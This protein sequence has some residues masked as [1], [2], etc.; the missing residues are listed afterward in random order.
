M[1]SDAASVLVVDDDGFIRR[2]VE[3]EC[4]AR[5][6]LVVAAADGLEATR[7]L[8]VRDFDVV[9]VDLELPNLD[10]LS[11]IRLLKDASP[12]TEVIVLT[13]HNQLN[14]ALEC[15]RLG[16]FDFVAKSEELRDLFPAVERAVER[17][18]YRSTTAL[19][20]AC[21]TIFA[22]EKRDSLASR[23]VELTGEAMSADSVVFLTVDGSNSVVALGPLEQPELG[24][25]PWAS[26]LAQGVRE[27]RAL[28]LHGATVIE[29]WVP[30]DS[31]GQLRRATSAILYPLISGDRMLGLLLMRRDSGRRPFGIADLELASILAS[32]VVLALENQALMHRSVALERFGTLGRVA[33]GIAHEVNNP[34]S[35]ILSNLSISREQLR[36]FESFDAVIKS[37][38]SLEEVRTAWQTAGAGAELESIGAAL[39]DGEEG[40]RRVRDIVREMRA[41]SRTEVAR[42]PFDVNQAVK[43]ALRF[44]SSALGSGIHVITELAP[45]LFVPG[46]PGRISQLIV[47]LIMNAVDAVEGLP[48]S[49]RTL[50]IT[51]RRAGDRAII[52]VA[53]QGSGI[54]RHALN[55]IFEPFFTT[56]PADRG[57]GLGLMLCREIAREHGGDISVESELG[58]GTCFS[59]SLWVEPAP[60]ATAVTVA[61]TSGRKVRVMCID[62]EAPILR[63][64][65]RLLSPGCDVVGV[66]S[67]DAALGLLASG[68]EFDFVLCDLMMPQKT[69]M[70]LYT[71]VVAAWPA[72]RDRFA[73][74]TG[75]IDSP[76]VKTFL[77]TRPGPV[78]EK[79]FENDELLAFVEQCLGRTQPSNGQA[80]G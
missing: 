70:T 71:E 25:E 73:F 23:V 55:Q 56:K 4:R 18:R 8:A 42:E 31:I 45:G 63:V 52:D 14:K 29:R 9:I 26:L 76:H 2:I 17:R 60:A 33:S 19:Y 58:K 65:A 78:L 37:A 15:L 30:T 75:S 80:P 24:A 50:R 22:A 40:A 57:T 66:D 6:F 39:S 77:A 38:Q 34:I 12:G 43:T 48:E 1:K 36:R 61:P 54:S 13:G 20:Q 53:D 64:Y 32:Q 16:A 41:F 5:G 51:S 79:P 28:V 21:Q 10:G 11:L 59:V 69:G 68:G 27:R 62:D 72:L 35:F 7:N 3:A 47:N 49:R 67:A 46:S 44:T 74:V